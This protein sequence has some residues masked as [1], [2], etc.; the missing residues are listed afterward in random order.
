MGSNHAMSIEKKTN[1]V[2]E[3]LARRIEQFKRKQVFG[4]VLESWVEQI[5]ALEDAFAQLLSDRWLD[6]AEGVQLD[7]LGS[8][9]GEPRGVR[10]DEEYLLGIKA[11]IMVNKSEGT[12]EDLLELLKFV[13]GLDVELTEISPA[14]IQVTII[15]VDTWTATVL[16]KYLLEAKAAGVAVDFI[17][18]T[19]EGA[20]RFD[21]GPGWDIGHWAEVV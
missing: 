6:T 20:F 4:E 19:T 3:A 9:V 5:Q 10:E 2:E 21:S 16:K 13:S 11:R 12:I 1:H 14:R 8:I 17:Y 15:G 7:G 18:S